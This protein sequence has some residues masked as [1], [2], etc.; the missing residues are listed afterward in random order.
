MQ[1]LEERDKQIIH[2]DAPKLLPGLS[3]PLLSS[4]L[5]SIAERDR[6]RH[7]E[8]E[9]ERGILSCESQVRQFWSDANNHMV[10]R[11]N[12]QEE[13]ER[14]RERERVCVCVL[15]VCVE[16]LCCFAC[17]ISGLKYDIKVGRAQN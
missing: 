6:H 15:C 17:I 16:V 13:R 8:R 11:K 9:R 4:P 7:R 10:R 3:S 1:E 14:E 12:T 5:S 2:R